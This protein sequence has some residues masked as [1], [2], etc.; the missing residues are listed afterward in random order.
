MKLNLHATCVS[1]NHQGILILGPSGAGKSDLALRL[2]MD[3]G[4]FLVSDDRTDLSLQGDHVQASC[5]ENIHG[6]LEVRGVGIL[7]F[8][9]EKTVNIELVVELVKTLAEVERLPQPEFY[10]F[11]GLNIPSLRLYPFEASAPSKIIAAL[12]QKS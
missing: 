9:T 10:N 12:I 6:L 11:T 5:P 7:N 2:I 4:A 3:K 1:Y 8:P